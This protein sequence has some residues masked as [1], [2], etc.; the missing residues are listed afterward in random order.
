MQH[1]DLTVC[2]LLHYGSKY[3]ASTI[4]QLNSNNMH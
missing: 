3:F 2:S 1:G 4:M